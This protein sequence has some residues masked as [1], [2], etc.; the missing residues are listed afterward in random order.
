MT[1]TLNIV[2]QKESKFNVSW[3]LFLDICS[4]S[5][6]SPSHKFVGYQISFTLWPLNL[7]FSLSHINFKIFFLKILRLGQFWISVS[8]LFHP[9]KTDVKEV[10]NKLCLTSK[11]KFFCVLCRLYSVNPSNYIK[12]IFCN[13]VFCT[14]TF[15]PETP[16]LA[17]Q[18]VFL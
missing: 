16:I 2:L 6:L 8:S 9:I 3:K 7:L 17:L 14:S 1:C 5:Y 10:L 11:W 4:W 15:V 13:I 18:K 12:K